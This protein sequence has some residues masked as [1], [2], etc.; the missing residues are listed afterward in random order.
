MTTRRVR[1]EGSVYQRAS[2]KKYVGSL[3][4]P[5]PDGG[6]ERRVVYG[7]SRKAVSDALGELK[8]DIAGGV[9]P[10]RQKV[11][12]AVFMAQW[13][14]AVRP[15]LRPMTVT[16]YCGQ[17]KRY[18]IPAIGSVPLARLSPTQVQKMLNDLTERGLSAA[19]V[20]GVRA[21]L[22]RALS[23]AERWG[24]VPRN[25]GR[26]VD[27]PRMVRDEIRPLTAAEARTLL[28]ATTDDRDWP[29]WVLALTTGARQ[30]E[31]LGLRWSDI[32]FGGRTMTIRFAAQRVD[33]TLVL[34][35]PKT[36]RSRRTIP[37]T[38]MAHDALVAH[39]AA[40]RVERIASG[41]RWQKRDIVFAGI[42]GG[43]RDGGAATHRFQD[44][45]ARAG[46][47]RVRFHDVRHTAASLLLSQGVPLRTVMEVLGHSSITVTANLYAHVAPALTRDA[48]DRMEAVLG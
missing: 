32:D 24:M 38:S 29:L 33:G 40:Q 42:D 17:T 43:I 11:T 19:T 15:S 27:P 35:E 5:T 23:Y 47:R 45:L 9:V 39:R 30:G 2:D 1:G 41:S 22:R 36:S 14:D 4:V 13:L 34:V 37:L 25:V 12:V 46:V 26:L 3:S 10:P 6:R 7:E 18:I 21:T 48:A 20:V 31:L 16:F 44:G 8:K 28:A